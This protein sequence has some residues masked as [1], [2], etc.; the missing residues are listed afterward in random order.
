MTALHR[1]HPVTAR[2]RH[3]IPRDECHCSPPHH[4]RYAQ[5]IGALERV[6]PITAL[7]ILVTVHLEQMDIN[8]ETRSTEKNVRAAVWD[9]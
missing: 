1:G 4:A 6:T 5:A 8:G 3:P 7:S 9:R 2:I